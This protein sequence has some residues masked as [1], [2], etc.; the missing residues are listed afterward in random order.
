MPARLEAFLAAAEPGRRA[1]VTSY[2]LMTGG[3]SRVMARASVEW[4]DGE[5]EVLVLR[6][7]PPPEETLMS[8]DRD[9]EWRLLQALHAAG[10]VA[11]PRPRYYEG[12]WAHLGTKCIVMEASPGLQMHAVIVQQD[13]LGE[14]ADQFVDTLARIHAVDLHRLPAEMERPPAWDAYLDERIRRWTDAEASAPAS[15]P[16]IRYVAAWLRANRPPEAPL[17]LVHGDAQPSNILLDDD[18]GHVVVDWEFA[19]IGDPREDLGYYLSYSDAVGPSLYSRDP[20]A[21]LARYRERTGLSELQVNQATVAYF[22]LVAT[23]PTVARIIDGVGAMAAGA[24]GGAMIT[25]GINSIAH[26][27]SS[28]LAACEQLTEPLAALRAAAGA[29]S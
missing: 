9:A 22:S 29:S 28:W 18:R 27:H 15:D 20:E 23:L 24:A 3:Y 26:V 11:V 8:S 10:Q 14:S 21:F 5:Q 6:G 7:D 13:D 25:Y 2:E 16:V 4:D 19:R 17:T 12:S 1:T